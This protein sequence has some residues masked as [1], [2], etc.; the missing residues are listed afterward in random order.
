MNF[1]IMP[2]LEWPHGYQ[3]ALVLML[4]AAIVPYY[5]FKLKKW[6]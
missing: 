4:V 2:E 1:K 5:I 3:F 6:L